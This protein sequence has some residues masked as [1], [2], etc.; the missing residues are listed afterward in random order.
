MLTDA[1]VKKFWNTL[2]RCEMSDALRIALRLL[3]VTAQRRGELA[4]ARWDAIDLDAATWHIPADDAKNGRAH[5]VPLSGLAV[6]LLRELDEMA[7]AQAKKKD[8]PKTEF[9]LA[10]PTV[11]GWP[12]RAE[13]ITR[14]LTR[15]RPLIKIPSFGVH[16]LR[17]TAASHMTAL[18]VPRLHVSK[19]LNHA[20]YGVTA[21]Y[22]RHDYE[23]EKRDALQL[24]ADH[25][26][27]TIKGR[28]KKVTPI[29]PAKAG[30][31][32]AG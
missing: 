6:T 19:V 8:E 12:I 28:K 26:Q 29:R 18:G 15:N 20:E 7:T 13:A 23:Q 14:A 11:K 31:P 2:D 5:T 3:L 22:D 21:T 17:R 32:A 4:A 30:L 27:A 25:L 16:D 9:V 10:S 1:E 24:W